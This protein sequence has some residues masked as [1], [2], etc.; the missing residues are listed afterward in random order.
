[1][2]HFKVNNGPALRHWGGL[3][4]ELFNEFEKGVGQ[5][6]GNAVALKTPPVNINENEDGYH[7]ELL[8]PGRKK[9]LFTIKVE[10]DLFT[11]GYQA[12]ETAKIEGVKQI[13]KEFN[14]VNF[15]KSFKLDEAIQAEGILAKY[16]DGILKVFL[17]K[18]P[19]I[20]TPALQINVQ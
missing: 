13:R 7:L 10:K 15:S 4:N 1:M 17:P 3:M 14:L 11:I 19:N 6:A 12:E 16:E 8:A 18:K 2:T 5:S 9:D 20:Q